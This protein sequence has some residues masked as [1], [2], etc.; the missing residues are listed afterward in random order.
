MKPRTF[1]TATSILVVLV[2]F[3]VAGLIGNLTIR[4]ATL[5]LQQARDSLAVA[6][7]DVERWQIVATQKDVAYRE[8]AG[9]LEVTLANRPFVA[10]VPRRV[11]DTTDAPKALDSVPPAVVAERPAGDRPPAP[12]TL[13]D[14]TRVPVVRLTDYER[15]EQSCSVVQR[16]CREAQQAKDSTIAAITREFAAFRDVN[17]A[18]LRTSL[19][20][21][22]HVTHDAKWLG[23]GIGAGVILK[24]LVDR[25]R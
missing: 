13:I 5:D 18:L 3:G 19:R 6:K 7:A 8:A 4:R 16:T 1:W 12:S 15:L 25:Q 11:F 2:V 20:G 17:D 10:Y 23:Y 21:T 9:R 14:T 22:R 24:T